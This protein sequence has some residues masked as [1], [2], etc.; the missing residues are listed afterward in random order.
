MK[1]FVKNEK[2]L[3][4]LIQTIR[5]YSQDIGMEFGRKLCHSHNEKW[6]KTK[7]GRELVNNEKIRTFR[8]N[9]N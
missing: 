1:L 5:I 6:K 8:E 4:T 3:E 9:K 7:K 2:E